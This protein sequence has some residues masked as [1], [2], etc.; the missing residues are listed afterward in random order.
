[1][2]TGD[3]KWPITVQTGEVKTTVLVV[4]AIVTG[5]ALVAV[6]DWAGLLGAVD[7]MTMSKWHLADKAR[8]ATA[9][10]A[11]SVRRRN[12]IIFAVAALVTLL[13]A[14]FFPKIGTPHLEFQQFLDKYSIVSIEPGDKFDAGLLDDD[15]SGFD[16]DDVKNSSYPV[17]YRAIG[18]SL[19]SDGTIVI[20]NGKARLAGPEGPVGLK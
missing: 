16:V 14:M 19:E 3:V 4:L 9:V 15:G 17:K 8:Q 12:I 11:G 5:V 13:A 1:M 2:N 7:K 18:T 20:N 6:L 10:E